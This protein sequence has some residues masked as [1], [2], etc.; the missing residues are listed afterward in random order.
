[1]AE[2]SGGERSVQVLLAGAVIMASVGGFVLLAGKPAAEIAE[3]Q[4]AISVGRPPTE[5]SQSSAE[6]QSPLLSADIPNTEIRR[7]DAPER[8]AVPP[9]AWQ[10]QP[11][12]EFYAEGRAVP[13]RPVSPARPSAPAVEIT[14]FER[15]RQTEQAAAKA[16]AA[17]EAEQRKPRPL[18]DFFKK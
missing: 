10:V 2:I 11:F 17:A 16:A 15:A 8:Q 18:G 12:T 5:A 9:V 13:E 4:P 6:V 3:L 1:M 7:N 14:E